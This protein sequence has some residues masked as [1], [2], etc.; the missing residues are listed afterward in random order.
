MQPGVLRKTAFRSPSLR[1]R[2]A[3]WLDRIA[4]FWNRQPHD[5][6]WPPHP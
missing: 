6:F 4:N 3:R 2:L 5:R 1:Q